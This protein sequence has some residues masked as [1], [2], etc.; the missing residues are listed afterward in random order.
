[1]FEI[2]N[3]SVLAYAN[4]FTLWHYK[5]VAGRTAACYATAANF[6]GPAAKMLTAGDMILFTSPA[7][8][9]IVIVASSRHDGVTGTGSV[10]VHSLG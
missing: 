8:G 5:A 6:F 10:I 3:L 1:M 7:G 4:A 9:K 2:R